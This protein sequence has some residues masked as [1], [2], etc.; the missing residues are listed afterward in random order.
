MCKLYPMA[1]KSARLDELDAVVRRK[2]YARNT[3]K[4][5][6]HWC[7]EFVRWLKHRHGK[8]V[9]PKDSGRED[10]QEWLTTLA[11]VRDVSPTTQNVAFQ[12]VLFLFREVLR[13]QIEDV[14]ALRAKRPKRIPTVLSVPEVSQLLAVLKG[15]NKLIAQLLYGCGLRIGE[16]LAL[17]VKD[18]NF[19]NR[20]IVSLEVCPKIFPI[21]KQKV[22]RLSQKD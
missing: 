8:W 7:A 15:R 19:G 17:R 2:G 5:Y 3:A 14:Q 12:S 11:T 9:N 13:I 4:T 21:G 16:A 20:Q 6:R 10:V 1:L 22:F 18:V